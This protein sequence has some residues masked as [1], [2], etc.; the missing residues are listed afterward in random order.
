MHSMAVKPEAE[1][2]SKRRILEAAGQIF[3]EK[4]FQPATVREICQQ[5]EVNIA[6]VNYY[7]GGK[8]RLYVEAVKAAHQ[9]RKQSVPLPDWTAETPA[10]EK[11]RDFI[12]TLVRRMAITE[13]APW[14]HRLMMREISDPAG[15]CAE[16][17]EGSVRPEHELLLSILQELLPGE[18]DRVRLQQTAF[19]VIGQCMFYKVG[20]PVAQLLL[21][22]RQFA[23]VSDA[24][25]VARHIA[26]F[27]LAALGVAPPLGGR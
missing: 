5:A 7:F 15:A 2:D 23:A 8:D 22:K 20:A 12:T 14:Q 18:S 17:V 3:A 11:L 16:L 24:E 1:A 13:V 25:S 10:D 6:A 4:G 26:E 27:T 19:S 9:Q 21:S